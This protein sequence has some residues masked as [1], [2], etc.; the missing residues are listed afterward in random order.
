VGVLLPLFRAGGHEILLRNARRE[1]R[2]TRKKEKGEVV[3]D[4]LTLKR[5]VSR[6]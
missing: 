6:N 4:P 3:W 5:G 1:G 2:G